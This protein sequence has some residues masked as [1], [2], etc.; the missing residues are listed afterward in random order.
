MSVRRVWL[1]GSWPQQT[2]AISGCGSSMNSG[3]SNPPSN[4]CDTVRPGRSVG[5]GADA[6]A[7]VRKAGRTREA[8]VHH[9]HLRSRFLGVQAVQEV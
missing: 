9:D 2:T 8:R 4:Q 1:L 6:H 7:L 5:A 3:F